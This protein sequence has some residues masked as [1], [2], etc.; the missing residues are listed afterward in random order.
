MLHLEHITKKFESFRIKDINLH[1]RKGEYFMLLG[2]S[3]AGKS[4]LFEIISGILNPD[5]GVII[6]DNET[7]TNKAIQKRNIGLVFQDGAVFP[8]YTVEQNILFPL[9]YKNISKNEKLQKVNELAERWQ[10]C[11]EEFIDYW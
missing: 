3:G 5:H 10:R 9:Q 6:L 2:P 8:H 1:I 4:V 11:V 7:I